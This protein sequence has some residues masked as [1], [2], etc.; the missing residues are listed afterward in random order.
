MQWV[1]L[2]PVQVMYW[3]FIKLADAYDMPADS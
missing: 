3:I 2:L 1:H